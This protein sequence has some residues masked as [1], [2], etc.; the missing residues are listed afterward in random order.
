MA[1]TLSDGWA[2]VEP[3][4]RGLKLGGLMNQALEQDDAFRR[5]RHHFM[6]SINQILEW[7]LAL[8]Q[9]TRCFQVQ[10]SFISVYVK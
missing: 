8:E 4:M 5:G 7:T 2:S 1:A 10:S 9:T 6:T 3:L